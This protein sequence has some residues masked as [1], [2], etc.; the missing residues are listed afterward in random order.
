MIE[1]QKFIFLFQLNR[2]NK[3]CIVLI[4]KKLFVSLK[5]GYDF[6]FYEQKYV[7]K[8]IFKIKFG[9]VHQTGKSPA[10][11]L[12]AFSHQKYELFY[13]HY[14]VYAKYFWSNEVEI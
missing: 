9:V 12:H 5:N 11:S 3:L 1:P 14:L 7:E 4:K 2:E 6:E 10:V 13:D 8:V